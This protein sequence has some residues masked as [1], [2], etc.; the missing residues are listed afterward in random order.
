MRVRTR[1]CVYGA[2]VLRMRH[3]R[4]VLPRAAAR[5]AR[6]ARHCTPTA[7]ALPARKDPSG[8][9][10][11]GAQCSGAGQGIAVA[12]APR[13]CASRSATIAAPAWR[14]DS[15]RVRADLLR[16]FESVAGRRALGV[17]HRRVVRS[18]LRACIREPRR[19]P[20]ASLQAHRPRREPTIPGMTPRTADRAGDRIRRLF[21]NVRSQARRIVCRNKGAATP[22]DGW[23]CHASFPSI[24]HPAQ[25]G[26]LPPPIAYTSWMPR[27]KERTRTAQPAAP[28]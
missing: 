23:L 10:R 24:P 21:P 28:S 5:N 19:N 17:A 14:A 9:A 22:H 6:E 1:L 18:D 25:Y 4:N 15:S 8:H 3:V 12:F 2:G 26:R 7:A 11:R 16:A 27:A 20:R 13:Q